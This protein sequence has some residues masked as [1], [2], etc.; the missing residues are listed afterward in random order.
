MKKTALLVGLMLAGAAMAQTKNPGTLIN[1]SI[2]DWSSFD[3]AHCYDTACAE[4]LQNTLETLYFPKGTSS[5]QFAPLL[6]ASMPT[7]SNGGKT[8]T[9]KLNTKARFSDGSPVTAADVKYSIARQV[10][11]ST[12]DGPAALLLE[13]LLGDAAPLKKDDAAAFDRVDK[14]IQTRG[15]D[16]VIFNLAKPFAPFVS[17]LAHNAASIYS[18]K[19][20]VAAGE[21]DGTK[22]SWAKF[23]N[24]PLGESKYANVTPLGSGPFV[25]QRYD[26]GQQVVLAKN[27][28]YWR[29]P[30]KLNVVVLKRVDEPATAVQMLR[31]GDADQIGVGAYPRNQIK[32]FQ[33][34]PGVKV[35]D[36]VSTLV[37]QAMF[38]NF[39]I[40]GTNYLGSAKMDEKG[41]PANFFSDVNVRRGFAASF[42]YQTFIKD[43]LLGAGTQTNTV[44][45]KGLAGYTNSL[46]YKFDRTAATNYFK[47]AWGGKLWDAGFTVPV[48]YNSGNANRQKAAEILKRN[49]EAINPKFHVD[50]REAQFSS[51]LADAA[52]KRMTVWMLGWQADYADPHNFAQPFLASTG[53]YPQN[54]G[55]KNARVDALI[56]QAVAT[57]DPAKRTALYKQIEQIGFNDVAEVP[58]WQGISYTVQ[59]D[60]VK[61][62][63][64]NPL[65]S[66][67]YYYYT[68][69]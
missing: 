22:A 44:L 10:L 30:A 17:A 26:K 43:Q 45:V 47:K 40:K 8:Y 9:I 20:A 63:V 69:K 41:I 32:N 34:L 38:M 25:L 2:S 29:A 3:P 59:R 6:A 67:D 42:D 62:R 27:A 15:N 57:T 55:Y 64:L 68:S 37:L 31:T 39:N 23:N 56:N 58:L 33:G 46:K 28:K 1:V 50:V 14:A 53:N 54:T 13:P 60:W 51:I 52:A 49:I 12:D 24:A 18:K 5:T 19:A 65:Y 11:M 35:I 21:W 7:I 66:G 16:T 48:F 61:G 4:V 36:N